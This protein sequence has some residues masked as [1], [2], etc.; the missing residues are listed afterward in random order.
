MSQKEHQP[1]AAPPFRFLVKIFEEGLIEDEI[2][3][4]YNIEG[5][6]AE[7]SPGKYLREDIDRSYM[8]LAFYPVKRKKER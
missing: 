8:T 2:L 7:E 1:H 3:P 5:I 4:P 6:E